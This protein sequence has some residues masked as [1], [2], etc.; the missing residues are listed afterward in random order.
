[1]RT[2]VARACLLTLVSAW[3][4]LRY[5]EATELRR[6]DIVLDVDGTPLAVKVR[7][8]ATRVDGRFIVG[9]PKTRAGIRELMGAG[10]TK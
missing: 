8:G 9:T 5:G 6:K 7:R 1:M 4:G 10:A 3:C 2:R